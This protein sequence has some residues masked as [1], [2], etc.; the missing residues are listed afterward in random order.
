MNTRIICVVAAG[1][2]LLASVFHEAPPAAAMP[3]QVISYLVSADAD[4]ND[5][6]PL[7]AGPI[8]V[9]PRHRWEWRIYDPFRGSDRLLLSLPSF[10]WGIRWDSSYAAV[11]FVVGDRIA[12]ARWAY[13]TRVELVARL[14]SDSSLC[15]FWR[16]DAGGWHVVTQ[17]EA[18]QHLPDGRALAAYIGTRWDQT[19]PTGTWRAAVVDSQAAGHYGECYVTPRLEQGAARPFVIKVDD[20]LGAMSLDPRRVTVLPRDSLAT[21]TADDWI[22]IPSEADTTV[23]LEMGAAQGDSYH[24]L[25]PVVWV[26]HARDRRLMVYPPGSSGNQSLGQIAFEEYRGMALIVSEYEGGYPLV[27]DMHSGKTLFKTDL[28]SARAV[29]VSAPR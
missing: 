10:P 25:E 13:G 26:D 27:V 7:E 15:D 18:L 6:T 4:S 8:N 28:R 21:R 23:G 2:A 9:M 24:A 12:R 14:P 22:W 5:W 20:L 11:E 1:T 3:H 16:D 19:G 29:W 17:R